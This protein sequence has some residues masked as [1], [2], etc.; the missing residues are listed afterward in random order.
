[1]GTLVS[2]TTHETWESEPLFCP[3]QNEFCPRI[4]IFK[5]TQN[6]RDAINVAQHLKHHQNIALHLINIATRPIFNAES[7]AVVGG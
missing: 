2:V 7:N 3:K 4:Q 1:M 6:H 5:K